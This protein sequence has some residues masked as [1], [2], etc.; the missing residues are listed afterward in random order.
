MNQEVKTKW[1]AAL[2]SGE[3]KQTTKVLKDDYGY[4][5]VGV[6]CHLY[7]QE[8]NV[9]WENNKLFGIRT[10]LPFEVQKWSG[11]NRDNPIVENSSLAEINDSG[12]SFNQ[13][14]D[15]IEKEL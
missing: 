10:T 3:Y 14:A 1:L 12:L 15:I 2:H 13:I 4:C 9:M 8:K 7:C 6:L 5:C 11:L